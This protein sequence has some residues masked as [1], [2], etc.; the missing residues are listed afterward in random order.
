MYQIQQ[1]HAGDMLQLLKFLNAAFLGDSE[2]GHFEKILP[3]MW[4]DDDA[5]MEKHYVIRENGKLVSSVGVYPFRV[6]VAGETLCFATVGNMG[7]AKEARGKGYLD[8]LYTNANKVLEETGVDI[9][10]LGGKR[11]R[12][13]RYGY[14]QC[15]VGYRF[16]L[17]THNAAAYLKNHDLP[18][19]SFRVIRQED[20]QLLQRVH[21]LYRKNGIAADRGDAH[22]LYLTLIS[23]KSVP[24]AAFAGEHMVGYF[25]VAEDRIY[26]ASAD[27]PE[28]LVN[29]LCSFIAG[30]DSGI[31][32]YLPPDRVAELRLLASF[33]EG[34]TQVIPSQYKILNWTKVTN[35][36]LQLKARAIAP[37]AD[38][39]L[40]LGIREYGNICI[41]VDGGVGACTRTDLPADLELSV[42]EASRFLFGV[43]PP[44]ITVAVPK[45]KAVCV[46]ANFPLPLYT[47]HLDKS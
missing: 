8:A 19:L 30:R 3:K 46:A 40:I 10:R 28:L 14:E 17:K 13:A 23:A 7:T 47:H 5:H 29:M 1:L 44:H 38:G 11:S 22:E 9:A 41:R 35:A 34:M 39:E 25:T 16:S 27:T 32:V 45:E 24:Y 4:V 12:Y 31:E 6:T 42:L 37:L 21:D 33:C 18:R 20:T 2:A 43:L 15:G 36:F 26:E